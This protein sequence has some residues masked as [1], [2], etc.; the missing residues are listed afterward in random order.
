MCIG[1]AP[2]CICMCTMYIPGTKRGQKT[3][4][5]DLG[6]VDSQMGVSCHVSTGK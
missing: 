1:I 2:V 4:S 5:D 6:L 3:M